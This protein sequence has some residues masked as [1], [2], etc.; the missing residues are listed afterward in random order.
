MVRDSLNHS[1]AP[2]EARSLDFGTKTG[3][4]NIMRKLKLKNIYFKIFSPIFVRRNLHIHIDYVRFVTSRHVTCSDL[5][6]RDLS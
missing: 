3:V 4:K 5:M 1:L 6:S 2:N